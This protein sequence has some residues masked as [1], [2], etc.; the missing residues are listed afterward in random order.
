[1]IGLEELAW[2][3]TYTYFIA[4]PWGETQQ[5][6]TVNVPQ[7]EGQTEATKRLGQLLWG[8]FAATAAVGDV[9]M[10]LTW[11][12]TWKAYGVPQ[13]VA[14]VELRGNLIDLAAPQDETP[15]L[16]LLTGHD[17]DAGRRRLFLPGAPR[18]WVSGG[19]LTTAGWEAL[20][21]HAAGCL[22]G[23]AE[24]GLNSG[25]EWMIAYPNVLE[26]SLTNLPGVAFRKVKHIRVCW[27]TDKAPG[28]SGIP[29]G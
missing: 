25:L 16:V 18:S 2:P 21:P 3:I 12:T 15:Q 29:E 19:F 8:S 4:T 28:P 20:L 5:T 23:L 9:S 22:L 11:V 1:M 6:L 10:Y 27:H 26:A 14:G 24:P 17:D 13:P 7:L